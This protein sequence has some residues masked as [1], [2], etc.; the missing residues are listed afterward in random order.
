[1]KI[2]LAIAGATSG[3]RCVLFLHCFSLNTTASMAFKENEEYG[4]TN[5]EGLFRELVSMLPR[6]APRQ[7]KEVR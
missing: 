5:Y 7:S 3:H 2:T 4:S 6:S 1:L